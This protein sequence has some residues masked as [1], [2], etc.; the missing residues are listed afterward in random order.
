MRRILFLLLATTGAWA[1]HAQATPAAPDLMTP[2]YDVG[3]GYQFIRANAPPG[4]CQCF[5]M[6]GGYA[7][8]GFHFNQGFGIE[9]QFTETQ[10]S[11]IS[12]LGQN[13]K[14]MTYTVG[15]SVRYQRGRLIARGEALVGGAHATDS[16]FPSSSG[17][18]TSASSL[19]LAAGGGLDL[20]INRRFDVRAVN[21]QFLHTGFPNGDNNSQ[22]HI[23]IG[24]GVVFKFG[25]TKTRDVPPRIVVVNTPAPPPEP[26]LAFACSAGSGNV[27]EG[28]DVYVS[29]NSRGV[30]GVQY[31]WT[32]T[33]GRIVGDGE[34]VRVDTTGLAAG[35]YRVNGKAASGNLSAD[36]SAVFHVVDK[37]APPPPNDTEDKA[38][39]EH[40]PDVL[41]DY[42]KSDIRPDGEAAIQTGIEYLKANPTER[43][44]I[45]GYADERGTQQYNIVLGLKRANNVRDRMIAAGIR[46]EQVQVVSY[47]KYVQVCTKTSEECF[48]LNRRA[49]MMRLP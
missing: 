39:H 15:P 38:F 1:A 29:G 6:N 23:T 41:F 47:G 48:Q 42:D 14:L 3:A 12:V 22:S 17:S 45:G 25:W 49:A 44:L 28:N 34:H 31:S 24:A 21:V 4:G 2:K 16:Y 32:S 18:M 27:I 43:V 11:G 26:V 20:Y 10:A 8:F 5:N 7:T 37:P 33:G 36:C 13:L 19:A 35:E 9:G 30:D 40:V 46:P